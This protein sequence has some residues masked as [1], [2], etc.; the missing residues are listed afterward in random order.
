MLV[1][2]SL[3]FCVGLVLAAASV[4]STPAGHPPNT[5]GKSSYP[6]DFVYSQFA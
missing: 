1:V 3:L 4:H 6:T 2:R 5:D